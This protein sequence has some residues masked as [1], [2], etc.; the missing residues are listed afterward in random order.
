[1]DNLT[2]IIVYDGDKKVPASVSIEKE[3]LTI[4]TKYSSINIMGKD[5]RCFLKSLFGTFELPF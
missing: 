5:L 1:M 4:H 3:S 2:Y